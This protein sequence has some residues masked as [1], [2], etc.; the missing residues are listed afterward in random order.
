MIILQAKIKMMP[1]RQK[2]SIMK[3][4]SCYKGIYKMI[5]KW[6]LNEENFNSNYIYNFIV[7]EKLNK[8]FKKRK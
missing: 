4:K 7:L 2:R 8:K 1:L 5:V 3:T 6:N